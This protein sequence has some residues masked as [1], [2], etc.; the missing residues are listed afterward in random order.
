MT[1]KVC[2]RTTTTPLETSKLVKSSLSLKQ[3]QKDMKPIPTWVFVDPRAFLYLVGG[4][5][6]NGFGGVRCD[7]SDRRIG[8]GTRVSCKS[9]PIKATNTTGFC[10][11]HGTWVTL[12]HQAV[13]LG[14]YVILGLK[15]PI[16]NTFYDPPL[17]ILFICINYIFLHY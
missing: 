16:R 6:H 1:E 10:S 14:E 8:Y 4:A 11:V 5:L 3:L 7:H 13:F 12:V 15:D 9:G 2:H 17:Q